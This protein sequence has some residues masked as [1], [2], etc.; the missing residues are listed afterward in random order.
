MKEKFYSQIEGFI[1]LREDFKSEG[2]WDM[3]AHETATIEA[4]ADLARVLDIITLDE[5]LAIVK[6]IGLT[7]R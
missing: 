7:Y 2:N 3:V 6:R 1:A 4:R 5:Y